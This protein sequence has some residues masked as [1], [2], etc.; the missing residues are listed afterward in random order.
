MPNFPWYIWA[1]LGALFVLFIWPMLN[2]LIFGTI[3]A[4]TGGGQ[5]AQGA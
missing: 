1:A 5:K 3:G 4:V 2:G